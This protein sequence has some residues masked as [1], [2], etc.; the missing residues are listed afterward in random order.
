MFQNNLGF[1]RKKLSFN[2]I[3]TELQIRRSIEDNSTIIFPIF[4]ENICCDPSLEPSQRDG[5]DDESQNMFLWRNMD[6]YP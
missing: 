2:H 1:G 6:N 3:S 4:H 5:S